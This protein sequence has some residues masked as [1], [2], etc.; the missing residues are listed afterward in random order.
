MNKEHLL[1]IQHNIEFHDLI[2]PRN[3]YHDRSTTYIHKISKDFYTFI[4]A[5]NKWIQEINQNN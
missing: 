1:K 5:T 2:S 3:L 4:P